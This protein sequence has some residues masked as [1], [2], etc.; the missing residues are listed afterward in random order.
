MEQAAEILVII[1]SVVLF[2]FLLMA[3]V[4]TVQIIIAIKHIRKFID[5]AED[6]AENMEHVA[7]G[8]RQALTKVVIGRMFTS[9]VKN[10]AKQGKRAKK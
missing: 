9:L 3:I 7:E 8:A 10:M 2:I 6:V 5:K 4:L 1:N